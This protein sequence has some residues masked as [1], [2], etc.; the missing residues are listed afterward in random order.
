MGAFLFLGLLAS[1]GLAAF[2]IDE[3]DDD[4][5]DETGVESADDGMTGVIC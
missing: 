3:L 4:D 1:V 5:N 2:V